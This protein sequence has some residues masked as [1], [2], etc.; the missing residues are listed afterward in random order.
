[1]NAEKLRGILEKHEKWLDGEDD[2]EV[3]AAQKAL[4]TLANQ[5]H[6]VG[7]CGRIEE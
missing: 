7:E 3:K 5:F 2:G 4:V 1:M 6:R